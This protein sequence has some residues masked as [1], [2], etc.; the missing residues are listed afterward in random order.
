MGIKKTGTDMLTDLLTG[1]WTRVKIDVV[2]R[3]RKYLELSN[4]SW[5][6]EITVEK[7][8]KLMPRN[9]D[10]II[11]PGYLRA[12]YSRGSY[13]IVTCNLD[14][15]GLEIHEQIIK[16]EESK[17]KLKKSRKAG[18]C[19]AM[20]CAASHETTNTDGTK[21][22]MRHAG[23]YM[24]GEKLE[25]ETEIVQG[26][27]G[28]TAIM[29]PAENEIKEA[30]APDLEYADAVIMKLGAIEIKNQ[31]MLDKVGELLTDV[32]KRYKVLETQRTDATK[33]LNKSLKVINGWYKPATSRLKECEELLK[34]KMNDYSQRL[35][36]AKQ[37]A[38]QEGDHETAITT[39][40]AELP[41]NMSQRTVLDY[42]IV[43]FNAVPRE[44]LSVDH[45]AV[46]IA[47]E[48]DGR[49]LDIPGIEVYDKPI[50]T[51]RS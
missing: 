39:A 33:P 51:V 19:D 11:T 28:N 16:E 25:V 4:G 35:F 27:D 31:G 24:S 41:S 18:V 36:D 32:K 22:C 10:Y 1:R 45:S 12:K 42:K 49:D 21:F 38:L 3:K 29:T 23:Q 26:V 40:P 8:K 14:S 20:R 6:S 13:K 47:L 5:L 7:L 30:A 48:R 46:K 37:Q 43:E 50:L 9:T 34:T 15:V 2:T 44:Y 17:M